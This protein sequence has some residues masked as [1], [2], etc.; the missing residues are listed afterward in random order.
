MRTPSLQL[1]DNRISSLN[2]K[3][4]QTIFIFE[5]FTLDN[6]QRIESNK[7]KLTTEVFKEN[8]NARQFNTK[9]DKL[10]TESANTL[11]YIIDTFF[12]SI[13]TIFEVY[14]K[15]SY[16]FIRLKINTN[17]KELPDRKIFDFVFS[18]LNI[19]IKGDI[20]REVYSTFVYFKLLRNSIIHRTNEKRVQGLFEDFISGKM[21]DDILLNGSQLNKYWKEQNQKLGIEYFDFS[22]RSDLILSHQDLIETFNFFRLFVEKIDDILLKNYDVEL[23]KRLTVESYLHSIEE[24]KAEKKLSKLLHFNMFFLNL[25]KS[26]FSEKDV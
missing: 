17:I 23:L 13:Y 1:F 3:L 9:L 16:S 26:L 4:S 24:S 18:E 5:Q 21:N 10:N 14:L 15:E 12:A 22:R 20:G 11:Q 8:K 19:D 2:N 25:D 7:T 6:K